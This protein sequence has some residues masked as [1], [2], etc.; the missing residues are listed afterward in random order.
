M[1]VLVSVR[2]LKGNLLCICH[3][4]VNTLSSLV[5]KLARQRPLSTKSQSVFYSKL[6]IFIHKTSQLFVEL[7]SYLSVEPVTLLL[8][9]SNVMQQ[10]S[11]KTCIYCLHWKSLKSKGNLQEFLLPKSNETFFC[12]AQASNWSLKLHAEHFTV[13]FISMNL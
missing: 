3:T 8:N 12:P 4:P 10:L 11:L 1:Y 13:T 9:R 2:D 6:K 5:C 7:E